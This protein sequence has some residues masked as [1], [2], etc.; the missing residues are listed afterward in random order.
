LTF[1]AVEYELSYG[2]TGRS[3]PVEQLATVLYTNRPL[4]FIGCSLE[5]DRTLA[6]LKRVH[7][8]NPYL[9]HY[10]ILGSSYRGSR[11][12]ARMKTLEDA[13]ISAL[14]FR[15]GHFGEISAILD[16]LVYRTAVD[17]LP[18]T[19]RR[20][21]PPHSVALPEPL[22]P[23]HSPSDP[24]SSIDAAIQ[25]L[26]EGRLVFFLGAAVHATRLR[27]NQFYLEVCE[28]AGIPPPTRGRADAAQYVEDTIGRDHLS[29]MVDEIVRLHLSRP[30]NVHV[31]L[32]SL[33]RALR[34]AGVTTPVVVMTTNWDAV[35]E[36]AF[37]AADEPFDLF[38]YNHDGPYAGTFLHRPP[39]GDEL[40]VRRPEA[41]R[42]VDLSGS[43]LIKMNG[44]VDPES[45]W[46]G[47]F[48]VTTRD[49]EQLSVR[50]PTVFPRVLWD[51]VQ[52]RSFLFW[53]HGLAE[54]DVYALMRHLHQLRPAPSWAVQLPPNPANTRYWRDV[55]G[56]EIVNADLGDYVQRFTAAAMARIA[57]A[58][59][60]VPAR[61]DA[62]GAEDSSGAR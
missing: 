59:M 17:V 25:A 13:G 14:W 56:V 55:A 6:S 15:P 1:T 22:F 5:T 36:R 51:L 40:V 33:P 28:R 50:M 18:S 12:T 60:S 23:G 24:T 21:N 7:E 16:G 29:C 27:G 32:A 53:G 3:G 37:A 19:S 41:Y 38:V 9:R 30:S 39:E 43:V 11:R 45:R 52:R 58:G 34:H 46:P 61:T 26:M 35:L 2:K 47:R 4:L 20:G 44:G 62:S 48:V 42:R 10:A 31:L 54:P 57:A 8:D 49:F